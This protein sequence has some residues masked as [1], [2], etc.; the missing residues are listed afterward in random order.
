MGLHDLIRVIRQRWRVATAVFLLTLAAAAALT[1]FSPRVYEARTQVFVS[2]LE[3]ETNSDLVSGSTYAQAQVGSYM[4]VVTSPRVL[5]PVIDSLSLDETPDSLARRIQVVVP[6]RSVLIDIAIQDG[7]PG[8]AAALA[9]T[10]T[11]RFGETVEKLEATSSKGRSRVSITTLRRA[12]TDNDPISPKPLRNLLLGGALGLALGLGAALLRETLDVTVRTEAD[13]TKVTSLPSLGSIPLDPSVPKRPLITHEGDPD[14]KPD[15]QHARA[16]AFRSLRTNLQFVQTSTDR[17][18]VVVTSSRPGEGKTVTAAN[19]GLSMAAMGSRVC[20]IEGDLRRPKLLD[21][22]GLEGSVGLTTALI[23]ACDLADVI[24]PY[25][26]GLAIVGAGRIPPN[27]SELLGSPRMEQVLRELESQFDY[28]IIDAPPL[29]PVTDA[30]VLS[31]I[32]GSTVIVVGLGKIEKDDLRR[33]LALLG[34]VD[35]NTVGIINNM[36]APNSPREGSTYYYYEGYRSQ[37]ET[38]L[39]TERK[40]EPAPV[41]VV[42]EEQS[43]G[44]RVG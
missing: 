24:Q 15:R 42:R 44:S 11:D 25:T 30:A 28:V 19:M 31:Q 33:A 17:R 32:A 40:R 8:Q 4:D 1:L 37:P 23:G 5:Q 12:V 9:N 29:L 6:D 27:P 36:V 16:E 18:S 26:E 43:A 34:K 41:E 3:N 10:I 38:E 22:L 20:I 7:D 35:A 14:G 13:V 21:Y 2:V 39:E